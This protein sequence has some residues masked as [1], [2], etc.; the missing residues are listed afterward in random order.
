MPGGGGRLDRFYYHGK[1]IQISAKF[2]LFICKSDVSILEQYTCMRAPLFLSPQELRF[3]FSFAI[4][5]SALKKK[6]MLPVHL[7]SL[8]LS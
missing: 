8:S 1:T 7:Y 6:K 4:N 5:Q 2:F 3:L